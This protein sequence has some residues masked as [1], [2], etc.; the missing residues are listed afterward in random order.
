[1]LAAFGVALLPGLVASAALGRAWPLRPSTTL[2]G[3]VA[4]LV[5]GIALVEWLARLV[6]SS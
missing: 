2:I 3:T 4:T 5:A 1:M 6:T